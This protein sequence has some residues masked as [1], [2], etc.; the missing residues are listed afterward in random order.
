MRVNGTERGGKTETRRLKMRRP[1]GGGSLASA[2]SRPRTLKSVARRNA[3]LDAALDEFSARGF[4]A[5]RLDD[6]A[7]RADVAKGTIYLYFRDKETLFQELVRSML[8]PIVEQVEAAPMID[9][10]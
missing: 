8:S 7:K 6:V 5:T 9:L 2:S 3:I 1:A 10:P 4:A